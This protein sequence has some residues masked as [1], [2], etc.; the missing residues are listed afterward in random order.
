MIALD[1]NV[2]LRLLL[3]DDA[4]QVSKAR[5]ELEPFDD[6]AEGIFINDVVL[7]ETLWTLRGRYRLSKDDLLLALRGLL[8]TAAF[9][10]ENR[11][12]IQAA[13]SIY[14]ASAADFSDCLVAAKNAAAG[15]EYTATFDRAM[16]G[17]PRVRLL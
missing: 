4:S 10:F 11:T 14:E 17:L 1:T 3:Q 8:D 13:V 16:H 9:A 2:L 7:A 15:C 12:V 6:S 5:K